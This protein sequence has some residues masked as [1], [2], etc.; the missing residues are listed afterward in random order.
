[1]SA[2]LLAKVRMLAQLLDRDRNKLAQNDLR[3][4][5][6]LNSQYGGISRVS[7]RGFYTASRTAMSQVT[8]TSVVSSVEQ[9]C[10]LV[11]T[12]YALLREISCSALQPLKGLHAREL[13]TF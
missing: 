8:C 2:G 12:N 5:V 9:A 7:A 3:Q 11:C 6:I 4:R 1:M 10:A 13:P